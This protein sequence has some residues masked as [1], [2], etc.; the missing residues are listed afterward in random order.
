MHITARALLVAAMASVTTS[1]DKHK[2]KSLDIVISKIIEMLESN[3]DKIASDIE[4]ESVTMTEYFGWCD[5]EQSGLI[6]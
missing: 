3:K 5:D 2:G 4:A 6:L 1:N